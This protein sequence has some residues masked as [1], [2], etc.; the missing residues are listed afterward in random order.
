[1]SAAFLIVFLNLSIFF[2]LIAFSDYFVVLPISFLY[3]VAEEGREYDGGSDDEHARAEQHQDR[4]HYAVLSRIP[5]DIDLERGYD[6]QHGG[7]RIAD[8]QDIQHHRHHEVVHGGKR[9]RSP[10]VIH[11]SALGENAIGNRKCQQCA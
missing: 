8:V 9:V 7:D 5:L 1:M 3:A 2:I 11:G 6:G 4:L 10:A